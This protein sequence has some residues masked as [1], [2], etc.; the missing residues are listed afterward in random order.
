[1]KNVTN[2]SITATSMAKLLEMGVLGCLGWIPKASSKESTGAPK[3]WLS[4]AVNQSCSIAYNLKQSYYQSLRSKPA[5]QSSISFETRFHQH[6]CHRCA[7][8]KQKGSKGLRGTCEYN[9]G[10]DSRPKITEKKAID[11]G[12]AA[13]WPFRVKIG[14]AH[15]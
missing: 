3:R 5:A 13:G 14:R 11:E 1:M 4:S 9:I 7:Q 15:V 8:P 6:G 2:N 10:D 12:G